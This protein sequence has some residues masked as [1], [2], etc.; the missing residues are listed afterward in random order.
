MKIL[1]L[2]KKFPYP[3]NDGESIAVTYLSKAMNNLGTEITLLSMNT[4]KHPFDIS[5]LPNNFNHYQAIHLIDID[6]RIKITDA[7]LNLFS[8][9]SYHIE[10]YI[11]KDFQE[12]L[13]ELLSN[14]D[15][16]IVHLETLYLA[17][18]L[19]TIRKHSKAKIAMRSH[20][21]EHEIWKRIT[22]N[23]SFGAKKWYLNLLTKRLENFEI[24][25]LNQY[26]LMVA[27]TERDLNFF[28]NLGLK[29]P[30]MVAPV[31]LD[32]KDYP[33]IELQ[34][35]SQMECCFIGSLDWLPNIEGLKW[36]IEEVWP[37]VIEKL[38]KASLHIAGKNTPEWLLNLKSKGITVHGEVAS[39]VNFINQYQM[40]LV[41]L[42]SGS[43]MRV[44]ILEGM[45]M[46]KLVIST[47]IGLEG[48]PA[49]AEKEVLIANKAMEFA[50][51]IIFSVN[52]PEKVLEIG[53]ASRIFIHENFDNTQ[54]AKKL[55]DKYTAMIND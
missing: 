11:S 53:T 1:Q 22:E 39:A 26:D 4:T 14:N 43:G 20:N 50:E 28:Y 31:G 23:S 33:V 2:T 27:M 45:A 9:L 16:D 38:P 32:L 40:M 19:E 13:I 49:K 35:N 47:E 44:K 7:F 10:R 55:L 42:H 8:N 37:L 30:S 25:Q 52:H 21:V 48:I 6:N 5:T 36:L 29:I 3:L 15:F 24:E 46:G 12:K 34:K 41:P 51:K 18:Y 54:I 17:P